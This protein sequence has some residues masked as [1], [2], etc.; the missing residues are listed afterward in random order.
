DISGKGMIPE[1]QEVLIMLGALFR[2]Q[3]LT[4]ESET[5]VWVVH[6]SWCNNDDAYLKKN[7]K[8][9]VREKSSTTDET[10]SSL[11]KQQDNIQHDYQDDINSIIRQHHQCNFF[12][13]L[14]LMTFYLL[15]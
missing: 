7:N 1:E 8:K 4:H 9:E 14:Y 6:M 12:L 11:T 13:L 2:I 15:F 10:I 3:N 5:A